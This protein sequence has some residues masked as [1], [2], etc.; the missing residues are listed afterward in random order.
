MRITAFAMLLVVAGSAHAQPANRP[1]PSA[2]TSPA[3]APKD[4]AAQRKLDEAA[5]AGQQKLAD[6]KLARTEAQWKKVMRSI[7]TGC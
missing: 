3:T 6:E 1:T 2:K 5:A 4:E 7:C